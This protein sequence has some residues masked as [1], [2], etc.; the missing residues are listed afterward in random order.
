MKHLRQQF[1]DTILEVG[2]DDHGLVV[3]VGDISHGILQPFA[4]RHPQRYYNIGV[5]EPTIVNMAAGMN[6]VGLTPVIH[7]IA[8]FLIER[9]YEQIKLDFGYQ[10]LAGNFVSVGGS[11]DYS[12]LGCSHHCYTDVS[13]MSHLSRANIFI[14]GSAQEFDALFKQ[15]YKNNEI[16]YFRLPDNP[17]GV[18]FSQ[19][20]IVAGSAIKLRDGKDITVVTMG[21][22][23]KS[24]VPALDTLSGEGY[25]ADLL[26][27]PTIK[28]FDH[29]AIKDS[30][31]KTG[32]VLCVEELS[33]HDGI[34]NQILKSSIGIDSVQFGQ[35]AVEDFVHGYGSFDYLCQ[36]VGLT[37][38]NITEQCLKLIR[39]PQ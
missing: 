13:L 8:P 21:S 26:Y 24:A 7:T 30:L 4:Q 20:L 16:N 33:A 11:F 36:K 3:L 9:A 31:R 15:S 35:I 18:E 34:F 32:R 2:S 6:K 5:C 37:Q 19:D 14:P 10:T 38:Q 29:V 1:A 17:H 39:E 27:Y 12:Q 28:P 25:S 22:H 23:L